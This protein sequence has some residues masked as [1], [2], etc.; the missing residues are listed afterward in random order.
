MQ[1]VFSDQPL[2]TSQVKSIFLAGPS[3]RRAEVADWRPDA[4]KV[5]AELGFDGTVFIPIPAHRF[6]KRGEALDTKA[7]QNEASWSYDAQVEWECGAR[8]MS[9]LIV[10]WVPRVLDIGAKDLGMPA[11]TTNFELGEDLASGKVLYGR[12]PHAQKVSYLDQRVQAHGLNVHSSLESVL[13]EAVSLLGAGAPRSGGEAQVPLRVWNTPAFQAW[14]GQLCAAGNRLDG[15]EVLSQVTVGASVLF[16]F[17]LKANVW[18]TAE[19]RHKSNEIV[20]SRPDTSAVL[21]AYEEQLEDGRTQVHV[22]LVREFRSS[23]SNCRGF[24]Y[25]L[26]AGSSPRVGDSPEVTAQQELQEETGLVVEDTTR[27]VHV[28][29]RQVAATLL[30]HQADLFAIKLTPT[31]F[32]QLRATAEAGVPLGDIDESDASG[33]RTYVE[34][35]TLDQA[36]NLPMDYATIGMV[37]EGL[38]K[39]GLNAEPR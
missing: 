24:V 30:T 32:A 38:R 4:L 31:E 18:V 37:T 36:L 5:L 2:P 3:P 35:V 7:F 14:Y 20:V 21:A 15:A 11:F 8:A 9:D 1:L 16:C 13:R 10:F 6:Q 27:F 28:G 17:T 12:P 19:Q 29:R 23:V 25:E 34:V 22:A 26:P 33:E 39:L